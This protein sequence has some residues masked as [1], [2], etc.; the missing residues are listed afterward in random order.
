[1]NLEVTTNDFGSTII[2]GHFMASGSDVECVIA[3][4]GSDNSDCDFELNIKEGG[5]IEASRIKMCGPIERGELIDLLK[6]IVLTLES[7]QN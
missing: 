7:G 1:M 2:K 3:P 4:W 6:Q 5:Q